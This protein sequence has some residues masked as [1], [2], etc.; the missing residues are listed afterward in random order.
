MQNQLTK[1]IF[2]AWFLNIR[3]LI[4]KAIIVNE[5]ISDNS[6]DV[7]CLIETWLKTNYIGLNESTPLSYYYKHELRQTGR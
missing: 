7:H 5:M 6:F 1:T 2:K 3:S 4:P